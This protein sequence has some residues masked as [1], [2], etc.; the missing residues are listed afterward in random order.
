MFSFKGPIKVA[1]MCIA[2]YILSVLLAL[3]PY[4][5]LYGIFLLVISY[6]SPPESLLRL[7]MH[8]LLCCNKSCSNCERCELMYDSFFYIILVPKFANISY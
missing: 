8:K 3:V 4:L 5:G 7:Y 2:D 1:E 6:V